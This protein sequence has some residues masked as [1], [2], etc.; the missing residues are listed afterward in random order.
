MINKI[1]CTV[2]L[3]FVANSMIAQSSNSGTKAMFIDIGSGLSVANNS[4]TNTWD[5]SP[6]LQLNIRAPFYNSQ[7]EAGVQ[8]IRFKGNAPTPTDSDFHSVFLHVGWLYP[9]HFS[10]QF[11]VSPVVRFG[12]NLMAFDEPEVFTSPNGAQ[13]FVTD[14]R[15]F[16]FAYELALRNQLQITDRWYIHA[17]LSYNRTL[18]EIPL[19]VTMVSAGISYS[20]DQPKWL[21]TLLQ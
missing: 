1:F 9:I 17:T 11:T 16:E 14:P 7:L 4:F 19:P 2:L 15:E 21:K 13:E 5:P 6:S 20:I 8:Y 3:L 12:G 10:E 18:T